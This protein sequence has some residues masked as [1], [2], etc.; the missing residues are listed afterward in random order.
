MKSPL[1]AKS[2]QKIQAGDQRP[3]WDP[4]AHASWQR[5]V[6]GGKVVRTDDILA[7]N[8]ADRPLISKRK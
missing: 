5:K 7:R 6:S 1:K 3:H 8:R 4:Q 2:P